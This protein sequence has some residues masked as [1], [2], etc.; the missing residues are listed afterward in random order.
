MRKT[1]RWWQESPEKGKSRVGEGDK[2][3]TSHHFG[4]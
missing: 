2:A 4:D 3:K 1:D